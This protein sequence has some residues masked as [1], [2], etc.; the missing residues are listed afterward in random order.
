LSE[1]VQTLL[2]LNNFQVRATKKAQSEFPING[3]L[4]KPGEYDFEQSASA[5]SASSILK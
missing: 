3:I 4:A 5:M 1:S 2:E